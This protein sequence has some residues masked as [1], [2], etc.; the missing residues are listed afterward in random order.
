MKTSVFLPLALA[1]L[2]LAACNTVPPTNV[3]QPMTARPLYQPPPTPF[4]GSIYQANT[5]RPLFEDKR[6]RYVGDTL[7]VN[8]VERNTANMAA[9]SSANRS[10]EM[11]AE[12]SGLSTV[13]PINKLSPIKKIDGMNPSAKTANTFEGGGDAGANNTFNGTMTVTV[14]ETLPNGN[15]LVSGEKQVAIGGQQEYIRLSGV[16]DP[17]DIVARTRSVDSSRI[18]DARI[19][20]KSSGYVSEAQI[21][22]WL[23]RFFLSVL[24]F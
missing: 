23:A 12:V 20:Y 9:S 5:T 18:A 6:P 4:N 11:S 10:S 7:T 22:G 8:L 13:Y 2:A 3:H 16:V 21:M 1:T 19:E 17:Y 15:L 14:I 24:P